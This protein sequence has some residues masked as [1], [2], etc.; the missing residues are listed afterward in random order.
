M[1]SFL[2]KAKKKID[3]RA[4]GIRWVPITLSS[5]D[6]ENK[7]GMSGMQRTIPAPWKSKNGKW[8]LYFEESK[9]P[10]SYWIIAS[11]GWYE[12]MGH[13]GYDSQVYWDRPHFIPTYVK[14]QAGIMAR[15]YLG[16]KRIPQ[17]VLY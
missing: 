5:I 9:K 1:T 14:K 6:R 15:K 4:V 13:I 16:I 2:T 7:R 10:G 17:G 8:T 12:D 11:N 3:V